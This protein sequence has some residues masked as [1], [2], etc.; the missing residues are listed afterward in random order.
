MLLLSIVSVA[1]AGDD[2]LVDVT[3]G[4]DVAIAVG[5]AIQVEA[6]NRMYG[7]V[8]AGV[9]PGPYLDLLNGT[10]TTLGWYS[11][12]TADLIDEALQNALVTQGIVG[13]RPWPERRIGFGVGYQ[14][15]ALGGGLTTSEA[16]VAVTGRSA[17]DS[18][19]GD[20]S[21]E[22][23]AQLHMISAEANWRWPIGDR[24]LLGVQAGWTSTIASQTA[25]VI[26]EETDNANPSPGRLDSDNAALEDASEAYLND[27]FRSSIHLP[28]GG[29]WFGVTF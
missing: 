17:R 9:Y 27:V 26:E 25:V 7:R 24:W 23:V 13:W 6:P 15:V 16:L 22:I 1:S 18:D 28:Y 21:A 2:W 3:V 8:R 29:V 5:A 20:T 11:D 14:F 19:S 4:T 12:G 10:A